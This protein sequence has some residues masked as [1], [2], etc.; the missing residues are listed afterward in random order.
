MKVLKDFN[1]DINDVH[2]DGYTPLHRACWGTEPRHTETIE[3]LVEEYGV[4]PN[5]KSSGGVTCLK[6]TK[7]PKT[8]AWL[9]AF[10]ERH[11]LDDPHAHTDT[12]RVGEHPEL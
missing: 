9:L 3:L 10:K 4:D 12:V 7:N 11:R 8:R 5:S 6:M 1:L 2:E